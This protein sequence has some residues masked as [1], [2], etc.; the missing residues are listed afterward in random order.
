MRV[1]RPPRGEQRGAYKYING[2][3]GPGEKPGLEYC[4]GSVSGSRWG[5]PSDSVRGAPAAQHRAAGGTELGRDREGG[6]KMK[7][8]VVFSLAIFICVCM[9]VC[10]CIRIYS[11]GSRRG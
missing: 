5:M 10:I 6:E 8:T 3:L 11:A 9:A 1:G 7:K 2:F 4:S